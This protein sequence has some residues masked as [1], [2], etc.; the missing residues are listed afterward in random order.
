M[1]GSKFLDLVREVIRTNHFTYSTEKTYINWIYRFIIFHNKRHPEE[2]GVNEIAEFLTYL[3]VDRKVSAS[4]QNQALNALVFLYKKVMKIPL[5]DFDFKP[6]RIAKRF[7]LCLV[8]MRHKMYYQ[9][10]MA[11]FILWLH[12]YTVADCV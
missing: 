3:A 7:L 6:A 5:N 9:I 4:T 11:N 8:A 1:K 10:F 2:M 12:C